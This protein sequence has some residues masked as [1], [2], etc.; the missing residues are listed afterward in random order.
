MTSKTIIGRQPI[1]DN[2]SN[3]FAYELLFRSDEEHSDLDGHY[4][5]SKVVTDAL[6]SI[7]LETLVGDK[8]AFVN[9]DREFLLNPSIETIPKEQFVLEILETVTIDD[10][11][12][13]RIKSL[14]EQGYTFALDDFEFTPEQITNFEPIF[15]YISILKIDV[16]ASEIVQSS[17]MLRKFS[18]TFEKY[19]IELLAEKIESIEDFEAYNSMGCLY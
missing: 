13:D 4:A 8:L 10:T 9:I 1:L 3:I 12:V 16:I 5:T 17:Q 6:L 19:G 15:P 14:Q 11:V 18:K 2:Q 7:G